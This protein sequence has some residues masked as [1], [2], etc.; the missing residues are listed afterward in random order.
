VPKTV[1]DP[2]EFLRTA[3]ERYDRAESAEKAIR[4]A[5]N[6]D[7]RFLAG[8]QWTSQDIAA[9][10]DP[11]GNLI[12]P[13][14]TVNKLPPF[15]D[16]ITNEQRKNQ[17]GAKVSPQGGGADPATAEIYEGLIRHIEYISQADVAYD[18]GF[19]YAVS[20]SFGYWRYVTEYVDDRST[21]QEIKVAR[22]KDPAMVRFDPDAEEVDYSDAKWCFVYR[23]MSKEEFKRQYPDSETAQTDFSPPGGFQ[24]QGWIQG[25]DCTVAE[26]WQVETE[27]KQLWMYRGTPMPDEDEDA[28]QAPQA[29]PPAV[30]QAGGAAQPVSG[31]PGLPG[32][33]Q[34][35]AP[36]AQPPAPPAAPY[37]ADEDGVV[38]RG[39]FEDEE[40]PEG[41]EPDLDDDGEHVGRE[42]DVPNVWRY[43]INGHEVLGK[44][45]AWAGRYIPIVPVLGKEKYVEGKRHLFSAIRF[46]LDSQQ[47]YNYYKTTEAEVI[48]LTPKNPYVGYLGQFKTMQME[49]S[50]ANTIPRPYLEVDPV[51]I[52][53][54]VAPLPTRQPYQP[55]TEALTL[56]AG[57]ANEDIKATTG[58]FDPSRGQ[59][60]PNADSGIAIGRLQQQGDTATYHFFSNF[61]RSM[62]HGYRILLD[63]IPKIYDTPRVVRIVRPDDQAELV[64]INRMFTDKNGKRVK[65]DLQQGLYAVALSVQ[66]AAD[67]R[68]QQAAKDLGAL[69]QADPQSLPQWADLYVKQLDIGPIGDEIAD[70]LTPPAFRKQDGQNPQ[71]MQQAAQQLVAQNQQLTAQVHQLAQQLE[72]KQYD[73]QQ[74]DA[75]NARDNQ[76]KLAVSAMQ[77]E[78]RR[79]SDAIRL[80][81]AE[82]TT[83]YQTQG[84]LLSDVLAANTE[85]EAMAHELATGAHD[86]AL[87]AHGADSGLPQANPD[88]TQGAPQAGGG[89]GAP[90]AG[91]PGGA[92]GVPGDEDLMQM[93]NPGASQSAPG[94][95]GATAQPGA[96]QAQ[97]QGG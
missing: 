63:L 72:T 25:D 31:A 3:R 58:R 73:A 5:A 8:D 20:S 49:W 14:L 23:T 71:Q 70:R 51:M 93:M 11:G 42:V 36:P 13:A 46:A 80:A 87:A 44:P 92:S 59:A 77:E 75:A 7:L 97:P 34:Q 48:Q 22:I 84:R 9:R 52:G 94:N 18:T 33:A 88:G 35:A 15:V 86:R 21:H 60:T 37:D 62:W 89:S 27:T 95:P 53:G 79:N 65:Y 69:A 64:Q 24:A 4:T 83:K 96:A 41:F 57:E 78:T 26:Y 12:R 28:G 19:D 54:Q 74:K 6:R 29:A 81:I 38:V 2:D 50:T 45:K 40:V 67:T 91:V 32:A 56:G 39:Y 43:D 10:S 85:H 82:I 68:R 47:L 30:P 90:G 76:T 16:G 1:A 61:L 17:S 55:A 66:P